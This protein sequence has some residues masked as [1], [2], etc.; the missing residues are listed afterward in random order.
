MA[1]IKSREQRERLRHLADELPNSELPTAVR[2]LEYLRATSDPVLR[3]LLEAPEDD[4]PL[5]PE[6]EARFAEAEWER[7]AGNLIPH[8]EVVQV[9]LRGQAYG[10]R[11]R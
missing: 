11:Q 7:K 10:R 3:A 1:R 5:T 6:E 2:M 8:D 4:E 9:E